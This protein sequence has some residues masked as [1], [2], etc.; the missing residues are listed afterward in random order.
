ML[1]GDVPLH[2]QSGLGRG[3][4]GN[5]RGRKRGGSIFGGCPK[6]GGGGVDEAG[7]E[8]PWGSRGVGRQEGAAG[9]GLL[10]G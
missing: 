6:G 3:N 4:G 5:E 8:G 10:S 7:R 9:K 1:L 2:H